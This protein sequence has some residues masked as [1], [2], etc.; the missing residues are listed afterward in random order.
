M[1][2]EG[3]PRASGLMA[4]VAEREQRVAEIAR[5]IVDDRIERDADVCLLTIGQW[6]ESSGAALRIEMATA[7]F[8]ARPRERGISS[9]GPK[10]A[11]W[12]PSWA[13]SPA[14]TSTAGAP[15]TL[16]LTADTGRAA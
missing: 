4:G 8:S 10:T 12:S 7:I 16:K 3:W 9:S 6:Q 11:R 1:R 13:A 14:G 15:G 2:N 5:S